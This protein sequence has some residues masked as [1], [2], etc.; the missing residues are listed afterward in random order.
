MYLAP[1]RYKTRLAVCFPNKNDMGTCCS[2]IGNNRNASCPRQSH[3]TWKRIQSRGYHI[4]NPNP[5]QS[6]FT[7][8]DFIKMQANPNPIEILSGFSEYRFV[9]GIQTYKSISKSCSQ[10]RKKLSCSWAGFT[11][12]FSAGNDGKIAYDHGNLCLVTC[13]V[14]LT[15]KLVR[16]YILGMFHL[17]ECHLWRF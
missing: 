8:L 7:D 4:S 3:W 10:I 16:L 11:M 17:N 2:R 15:S 13:K 5:I 1:C 6:V 12:D 9:I 14:V